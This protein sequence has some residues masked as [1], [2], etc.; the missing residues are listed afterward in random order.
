MMTN[1]YHPQTG[2]FLAVLAQNM[3]AI[4][5]DTMQDWIENPAALN[6]ALASALMPI[7][8]GQAPAKVPATFNTAEV[9]VTGPDRYVYNSF[10][11]RITK[12]YP[13]SIARR[14]SR[15]FKYDDLQTASRDK[16]DIIPS[17]GGTSDG[18]L[19]E[20]QVYYPDEID[21][22]MK[23]QAKGP[24]SRHGPLLTNGFANI[25]YVIGVGGELFA[26][27]VRWDVSRW[28]V[29]AGALDE[30]GVHW[31]AGRRVFRKH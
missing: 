6:V 3:P 9:F 10:T 24:K 7:A 4:P 21:R 26:V 19:P 22:L 23:H 8:E 28:Y 5:A 30:D 27:S 1:T 18:K 11:N 15:G 12:A 29:G 2:K 20:S 17:L 31:S 14:P 16:R 13:G 25:F